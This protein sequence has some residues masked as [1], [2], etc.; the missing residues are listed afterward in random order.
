M[1]K[2][3]TPCCALCFLSG[4]GN[5]TTKEEIMSFVDNVEAEANSKDWTPQDKTSGERTILTIATNNEQQLKETLLHCGFKIL[6]DT[7]QR[8]FGYTA[9]NLTLLS[10]AF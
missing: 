9:G 7:L 8:R 10:Y 2:T 4:I 1:L 3:Q 5:D 6:D